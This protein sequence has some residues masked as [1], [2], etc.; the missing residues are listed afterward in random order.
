MTNVFI[1]CGPLVFNTKRTGLNSLITSGAQ[2]KT[3]NLSDDKNEK[4]NNSNKDKNYYVNGVNS[5]Y[6]LGKKKIFLKK[7]K[8]QKKVKTY[9]RKKERLLS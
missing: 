2:T 9:T 7:K 8:S 3:H 5:N 4:N 1:N 6:I